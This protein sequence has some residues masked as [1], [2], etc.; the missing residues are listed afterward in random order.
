MRKIRKRYDNLTELEKTRYWNC[1]K[2]LNLMTADDPVSFK[3]PRRW[4]N[5]Y[6]KSDGT[7]IKV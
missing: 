5:T 7:S 6:K 1:I 2:M 4:I 3:K